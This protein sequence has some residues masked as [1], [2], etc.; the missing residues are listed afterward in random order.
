MKQNRNAPCSCGSGRKAKHCCLRSAAVRPAAKPG[1]R[2]PMKVI[3][4]SEAKDG[5][6]RSCDGCQACCA[7][8]LTIND[9]ELVV[10]RGQR[11]RNLNETG[12]SIYGSSKP[13]TCTGFICNYLV[14]PG[15]LTE[16]DRPDRVGAIVRLVR[17]SRFEPPMDRVVH[18]NEC[19][20]D[21]M[22]KILAN[23]NW[24]TIIRNDL[25]AGIPLL[26]S[27]W[28]DPQAQEIVHLRFVDGQ[29]RCELTSC[30]SD[31]APILQVD[32]PSYDEP[33]TKALMIP[34]SFAFDAAAL[35][36]Q[37]GD[38]ANRVIGPSAPSSTDRPLCFWFTR[39][40]AM[41]AKRA[42][43]LIHEG[44]TEFGETHANVLALQPS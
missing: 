10:P 4:R 38:D 27:F 32:E 11:C 31:G 43:Q 2:V 35:I 36:Q 6:I 23:P 22:Q 42:L 17:D 5:I 33:I 8:A 15:G 3:Q 7:G 30:D 34:Q 19:K 29:L 40:Q 39:R 25:V 1:L 37:L 16:E 28:D 13:K 20:P 14:E 44:P 24:G 41:F 9:P 26:C 12:C 18:L 21:G